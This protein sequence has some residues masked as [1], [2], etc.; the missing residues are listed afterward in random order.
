MKPLKFVRTSLNDLRD[1]PAVA[2]QRA[3]YQLH[4]VQAG[5]QPSVWKPMI[6]IGPCVHEIRIHTCQAFRVI[7]VAH[8]EGAVFVL[9]AFRKK[10]KKTNHRDLEIAR[11]R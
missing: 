8:I 11:R 5:Q 4:K 10:T 1:F 6:P 9:H 2:R 7:H 3:G